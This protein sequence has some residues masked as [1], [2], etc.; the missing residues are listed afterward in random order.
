LINLKLKDI[1]SERMIINIRGAKGNKDRQIM[2]DETLL[3]LLREYFLED[4]PIEY[5][6]NGQQGL[7]YTS[8]SVNQL[9]K[10]YAK[11]VGIT[12]R[13][14]A[15]KMRHCFATHLLESGTDMALIQKLLG[16]SNIKTTQ[17]YA[18]VSTNLISKINSPLNQI[19][20]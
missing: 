6:F 11:K 1:D 20:L 15:H 16:H 8:S 7:Q 9:L 19:Q 18:K 17:I 14:H 2:L 5:L 12:K 10:H 13:I 3:K 4:K